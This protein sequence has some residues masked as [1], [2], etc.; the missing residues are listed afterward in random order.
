M[1]R[2]FT[3]ASGSSG[4]CTYIGCG[5]S[6]ILI[7]AGISAKAITEG[8]S[9]VAFDPSRLSAI[10]ITH[11]HIDH[12]NGLRVFANKYNIPVF[13]SPF[14]CEA[15]SDNMCLNDGLLNSFETT[16]GLDDMEITRF[17][18]SHDC[19]GSSGYT[20]T[21]PDGKKCAVCTDLGF[22]S[23]EVRSALKGSSAILIESNHDVN[24][25]Q[26][27]TYPEHLKRRILSDKGHLSNNACAVELPTLVESGTT[28]IVLGHLSREN[29]KQEIAHNAAVAA[30]MD[31]RMKENDDFLL[32]IAPPKTGRAV[33][34]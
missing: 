2:I 18:T 34:F 19:A 27:G 30:L 31:K 12:I 25:L 1:S 7:D 13:A 33:L 24:L 9:C 10:F 15:I 20:V 16:I 3:I 32:Y 21:L 23:E 26:K 22:V 28:R 8:L 11:E 29:N 17:A 6:G 5:K 14:T 4:N